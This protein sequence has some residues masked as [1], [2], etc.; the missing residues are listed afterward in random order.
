[1]EE[2][3]RHEK[4]RMMVHAFFR[5]ADS[6]EMDGIQS[7]VDCVAPKCALGAARNA[8]A[9]RLQNPEI[10]IQKEIGITWLTEPLE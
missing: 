3:T 6:A 1:M 5:G 4:H 10:R 9:D 7:E 2:G 8:M